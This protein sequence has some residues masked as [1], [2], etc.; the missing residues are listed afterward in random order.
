MEAMKVAPEGFVPQVD[1]WIAGHPDPLELGFVRTS[2]DEDYPWVRF[3]LTRGLKPG[4][5]RP[6]SPEARWMFVREREIERVEIRLRE[7]PEFDF[8]E[9]RVLDEEPGGPYD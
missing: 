4:E 2:R 6:R 1:V 7:K 8:D 5:E 3:E 9:F